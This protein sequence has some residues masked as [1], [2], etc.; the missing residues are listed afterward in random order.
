MN[1][2][3]PVDR[4][5]VELHTLV[6]GWF[7]ASEPL[8]YRSLQLTGDEKRLQKLCKCRLF[9]PGRLT[10]DMLGCEATDL[11]LYRRIAHPSRPGLYFIGFTKVLCSLWPLSEQ[12][13]KWLAGVLRG[14]IALPERAEQERR[15]VQVA[16]APPVFCNW[17]VLDLRSDQP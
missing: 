11:S 16:K 3:E 4:G 10:L 13:A 17:D 9:G 15:A 6:E 1:A 12:Q 8:K 2:T 5:A 14:D 7:E